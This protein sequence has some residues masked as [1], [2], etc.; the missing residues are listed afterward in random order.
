MYRTE[1][2]IDYD[3]EMSPVLATCAACGEK[4]PSPPEDLK[5]SAEVISWLS[6]KYVEHRIVKHSHD[7]RRRI[8]RD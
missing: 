7:E 4:M 1:L 3:N 8:R 2:K 6:G 5:D